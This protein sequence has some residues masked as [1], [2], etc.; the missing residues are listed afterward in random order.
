MTQNSMSRLRA[1]I[2]SLDKIVAPCVAQAGDSLAI[3][4][5]RLISQYLSFVEQRLDYVS[6]RSRFELKQYMSTASKVLDLLASAGQVDAALSDAIRA[7]R[8]VSDSNDATD[9]DVEAVTAQ[10]RTA[11]S[12]LVRSSRHLD[13]GDAALSR[14][15]QSVVLESARPLIEVQRAWFAPQGWES[16][17]SD[18]P[19]LDDL[20]AKVA[21]L[22]GAAGTVERV[23]TTEL[24][25]SRITVIATGLERNSH[26]PI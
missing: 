26:G 10:L 18:V 2:S 1:C 6:D 21:I 8:A 25:R 7:A 16:D 15:V 4:Q 9:T 13:G 12:Y 22:T 19:S 3:E 14:Q 23:I 11:L 24:V 17:N 20:L 5:T